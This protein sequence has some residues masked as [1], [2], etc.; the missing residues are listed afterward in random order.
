M[1]IMDP[2]VISGFQI[3]ISIFI[4]SSVILFIKGKFKCIDKIDQRTIRQSKA[5]LAAAKHIDYLHIAEH[6]NSK[7]KSNL[8][9]ETQILLTDENGDL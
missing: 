3:G 2:N 5:H 4:A 9:S 1:S 7:V 8:F 6:G